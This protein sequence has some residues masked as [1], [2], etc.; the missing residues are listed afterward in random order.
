MNDLQ[1]GQVAYVEA[2]AVEKSYGP[3]VALRG[4]SARFEA[5]SVTVV[6]G[7]NGAGKSTL[8]GVLGGFVRP[9]RG[10]VWF[11]PGGEGGREWRGRVGWVGH[12]G[13]LYGG[14]SVR[15]NV[16]LAARLRGIEAAGAWEEVAW[17]FGVEGIGGRLTREL[18]RGQR[19]RVALAAGMVGR[20]AVLLLDEP[21]TGL[22]VA[23][24][25]RL[26]GVIEEER[27]RGAVV[28]VVAHEGDVAARLG[29]RRVVLE[30]GLVVGVGGQG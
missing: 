3:V 6:E 20:P 16:G 1:A 14:L 26:D 9:T 13:Y 12:E 29:G 7:P 27:R 30:R 4:V 5:G 24:R 21:W 17:R 8:L 2:R 22:D 19:Q 28:V 25:T 15:E 10:R 11:E 23:G 18:S